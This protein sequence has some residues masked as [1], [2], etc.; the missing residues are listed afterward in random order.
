MLLA[1]EQLYF[2]NLQPNLRR[3]QRTQDNVSL[4]RV[5]SVREINQSL[6]SARIGRID[7]D[8][9]CA[10]ALVLSHSQKLT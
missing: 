3:T 6:D 7:P 4:R 2:S 5:F 10:R 1:E 8:P 9:K